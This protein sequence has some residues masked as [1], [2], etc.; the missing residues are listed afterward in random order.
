VS[1]SCIVGNCSELT[2]KKRETKEEKQKQTTENSLNQRWIFGAAMK[3]N[4]DE[5][6][7][8]AGEMNA[9]LENTQEQLSYGITKNC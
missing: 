3:W 8:L 4:F 7:N 1:P 5:K 2:K 9:S 6:E